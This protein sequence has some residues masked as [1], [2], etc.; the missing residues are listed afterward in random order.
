[1]IDVHAHFAEE[2]Y[3]FPEEWER[4][5]LSGVTRVILAGDSVKHT[6]MHR[7]FCKENAGAFYRG[8][9]SLRDGRLLQG[10]R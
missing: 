9:A 6:K 10:H 3:S 1:M 7:D 4:I 5:R 8:R 2:G